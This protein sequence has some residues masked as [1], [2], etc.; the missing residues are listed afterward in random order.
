MTK[1]CRIFHFSALLKLEIHS[2][3]ET[4]YATDRWTKAKH[5]LVF[6]FDIRTSNC[7]SILSYIRKYECSQ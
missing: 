3:R 2:I 6:D 4:K 1:C 5:R 7:H